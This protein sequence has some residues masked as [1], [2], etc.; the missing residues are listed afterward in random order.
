MKVLVVDDESEV[1]ETYESFFSQESGFEYVGV[2][3][4][5][6][7]GVSLWRDLHPDVT[8]MDLNIPLMSGVEAIR[9]ICAEDSTACVVAMTVCDD[10]AH[11]SA[12][13]TAGASGY[14]LKSCAP[15]EISQGVRDAFNQQMPLAASVR[16]TMVKLFQDSAP[17]SEPLS[18]ATQREAELLRAVV[19]GLTNDKIAAQTHMSTGS[20]K[21]ALS[22]LFEKFTVTSRTDLAV[23]AL[24][25]GI[26]PLHPVWVPSEDQ[27]GS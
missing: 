7:R 22:R 10:G 20:V 12:A 6:R 9:T 1:R 18:L 26:V 24:R 23:E 21:V 2:A 8:L 4:N 15:E 5:G 14:L 17:S 11:V 25:L 27:S 19:D 16:C 3:E 13:L